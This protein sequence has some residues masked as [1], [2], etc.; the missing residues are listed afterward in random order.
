MTPNK[1]ETAVRYRIWIISLVLGLTF[2]SEASFAASESQMHSPKVGSDGYS[3]AVI[4]RTQA[5]AP[6]PK[7]ARAFIDRCAAHINLGHYG[8][9]VADCTR[10]IA[11]NPKNARAFINRCAAYI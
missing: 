3:I 8:D 6:N 1:G 11:L 7:N 5:S 9:A 2:A 10:A 4:E